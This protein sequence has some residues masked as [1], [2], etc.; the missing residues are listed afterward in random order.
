MQKKSLYHDKITALLNTMTFAEKVGQMTQVG[1]SIY[2]PDMK[3]NPA[4][5]EEIRAA[6]MGS[7]LSVTGVEM[8]NRMQRIA[9]EE[10]RLGIPLFFAHDIIHGYRTI[11]PVPL[12]EACSFEPKLARE[13]SRCIAAEARANG[14]HLTFAPMVDVARD[15]RWGRGYEGAGED[16]WL[17]SLFAKARV[18][19]LQNGDFKNRDTIAACAKHFVGYGAVQG[20]RDYNSVTL[21]DNALYNDHLP[22]FRAAVDAG[23][24]FVMTAFHDFDGVPCTANTRL[25]QEILREELGFD[26]IIISD[27]NSLREL[28]NHG[29]AADTAETAQ[30]GLNAGLDVEMAGMGETQYLAGLADT[31]ENRE[32]IDRAVYRILD[33]KFRLGLFENPY[34]DPALAEERTGTKAAMEAAANAAKRSIVLLENNGVLPV[35]QKKLAVVGALAADR[36]FVGGGWVVAD[37][38]KAYAT[39]V[40]VLEGLRSCGKFSQVTYAPGYTYLRDNAALL[41]GGSLFATDEEQ[42]AQAVSAAADSDVILLVAGEH[43]CM[44]GEAKSRMDLALPEAVLQLLDFLKALGKPIVLLVSAGRPLLLGQVKDQVDALLFCYPLGSQ[45]GTAVA[46]VLSGEYNP[47]AKLVTTIPSANGQ[48]AAMYYAQ[49][50]TGKPYRLDSTFTSRYI[51]GPNQ[52]AYCF[53]FG[54]SY[55]EFAYG[56]LKTDRPEYGFGDTVLLSMTVENRGKLD[57]ETVAQVY[58]RDC[59]ASLTRPV[60][61][62]I[63]FRKIFLRAGETQEVCFRL[64]TR[65]LGF[66]K[67]RQYLLE[68]G[69]W[70]LFAGDDSSTTTQTRVQIR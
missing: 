68:P 30:M 5:A 34:T 11:F 40:T 53:G 28:Q 4:V 29:V 16:V 37:P 6:R 54:R 70:L 25:L 61:Q 66:Y 65:Q 51:D 23:A 57:G 3:L 15:P 48:G 49:N 41:Q 18:E 50:P 21:G 60:K 69:T 43:P 63:A 19:G 10:T 14:F 45:A 47:S 67:D 44:N 62:L 9:V 8:M 59:S 32:A 42:T 1:T 38:E 20:G 56:D 17:S 64:D 31:P 35:M 22:P 27:A 36:E 46:Q 33:F 7:F 24:E 2:S 55:T 52:P 39:C 58:M 26:G 12:A 13:S